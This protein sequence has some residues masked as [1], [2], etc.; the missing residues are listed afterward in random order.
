MF[1]SQHIAWMKTWAN[2]GEQPCCLGFFSEFCGFFLLKSALSQW[3]DP[4]TAQQKHNS[5]T[6]SAGLLSVV[7]L[8]LVSVRKS[9]T[10]ICTCTS[11]IPHTPKSPPSLII[12]IDR[13]REKQMWLHCC[14]ITSSHLFG[15]IKVI[16]SFCLTF[17]PLSPP[18][19]SSFPWHP[20]P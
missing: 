6:V 16:C 15:L 14:Q 17:T 5:G 10:E 11:N 9:E 7:P 4:C 18:L 13:S 1:G 20:F 12:I 2:R 8:L 3:K 19:L